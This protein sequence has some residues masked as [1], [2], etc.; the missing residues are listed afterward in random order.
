MRL[1]EYQRSRE[2]VA[3][4]MA[5]GGGNRAA[6]RAVIEVVMAARHQRSDSCAVRE[7]DPSTSMSVSAPGLPPVNT[8]GKNAEA[9]ADLTVFFY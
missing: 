6:R 3:E 7:A 8:R 9:V 5:G 2:E 1:G 4:H